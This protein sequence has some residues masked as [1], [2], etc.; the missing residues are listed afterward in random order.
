MRRITILLIIYSL[1]SLRAQYGFGQ[2]QYFFQGDSVVEA[3][4]LQEV[5]VYGSREPIP[6]SMRIEINQSQMKQRNSATVA[7]LLNL[8]PGLN[9]KSG[10]KG[11]TETRIRAFRSSEVLVLVDGRPINPGYYGK[12][13][14][15][16]LPLDNLAKITIVK[17]PASV[18][19][20]ANSMGGVINIITQNGMEK[21]RTVIETKFGDHQF[22]QLN[23]NHSRQIDRWNYWFSAYEH[24]SKGFTMSQEFVPTKYENGGL[25]DLSSYHKMGI[26]GKLGFQA[27]EKFL[28]A[29]AS[30][31]HWAKKDIPVATR[32]VPGDTPRYWR[33]PHWKR[34]S[35][36]LSSEWQP[37]P[38]LLLKLI[39]FA[40]LYNDRLINYL[41]ANMRD[42]QIDYDSLLENIT[43]GGLMHGE[44]R[45][46]S[47]HHLLTG[48]QFRKDLMEKKAD[49]E[50]P[51]EDHF[52]M[53]G[54]IFLQDDFQPWKK[55]TITAGVGYHFHRTESK[56]STSRFA[57]MISLQ[58]E[59]PG[60]WKLFSSYSHA[61]RFPVLHQL[62]SA[63]SGNPELQ[64]ENADKFELGINKIFQ[65]SDPNRYCSVDL[66]VF[67]NKMDN[68]IYR[69]TRS[70]RFKNLAQATMQGAEVRFDWSIHRFLGGEFCYS[71]I[72]VP[73]SAPEISDYLPANKLRLMV[74]LKTDFRTNLN[75]EMGYVDTRHFYY[76][77]VFAVTLPAYFVHNINI[78]YE[79]TKKINMRLEASNLF[80]A[81]YEE[82]FGYPQPGRQIIGGLRLIL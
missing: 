16:M 23:L 44:Y 37:N 38:K 35:T 34:S 45:L 72:D 9:L 49:L 65:F 2:S 8:E 15:S 20:G 64:P 60:A 25:R 62:Y 33:F 28:L 6:A 80:D 50:E 18:A 3:Y 61:I 36:T 59:L 71:Y 4:R 19:Y 14:L 27:T 47:Q 57:P 32:F 24:Y 54:S 75:Y 12:V 29:L 22:R 10:Y 56:N 43:L 76:S 26:S 40:D 81:Q 1:F 53:T 69:A 82:E 5:V 66:A 17:G 13:D 79:L 63:T 48:I 70:L 46:S 42:D 67:Y 58:Q 21:P 73:R 30:D 74:N 41:N 68:M 11:E 55:T 39:L 52:A 78:S 31:Y 7:E 77:S 51:W